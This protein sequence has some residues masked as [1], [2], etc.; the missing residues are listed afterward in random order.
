M[1]NNWRTSA[2]SDKIVMQVP[3]RIIV[4]GQDQ[5]YGTKALPRELQL[6][7]ASAMP[8]D[9]VTVKMQTPPRS[10]TLGSSM[11]S[12]HR[13]KSNSSS[14]QT[15]EGEDDTLLIDDNY[16]ARLGSNSLSKNSPLSPMRNDLV[17]GGRD[18]PVNLRNHETTMLGAYD[19]EIEHLRDQLSRM[20]RR[21]MTLEEE[22]VDRKEKERYFVIAGI[23]YAAVHAV[24]WL[25]RSGHQR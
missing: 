18:T 19:E 7:S 1:N 4:R 17:F 15:S 5:H 9:P 10:I 3:D 2:S 25:F 12:L 22:M 21:V 24:T 13:N 11:T 16:V 14:Q 8:P 23:L 6:E 20:N